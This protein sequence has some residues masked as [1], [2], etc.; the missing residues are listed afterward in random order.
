M[1]REYL[2]K[3]QLCKLN[4]LMWGMMSQWMMFSDEA[5]TCLADVDC[6]RSKQI[7]KESNYSQ[8]ISWRVPANLAYFDEIAD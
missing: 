2:Q 3:C 4:T 5:T 1:L 7:S 8:G 6:P